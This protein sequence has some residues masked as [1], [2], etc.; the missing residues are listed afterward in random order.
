MSKAVVSVIGG[1]IAVLYF[2]GLLYYFV[3]NAGS[4]ADAQAIGLGPTLLGLGIIGLLFCIA[5]IVK[6]ARLFFMPGASGT[7]ARRDAGSSTRESDDAFDADAVIARHMARRPAAQ[8]SAPA[9]PAPQGPTDQSP[10]FGR[11]VK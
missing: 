6:V 4:I 9:A 8:V 3:D 1:L 7:P 5:L 2:G 11:R 10:T